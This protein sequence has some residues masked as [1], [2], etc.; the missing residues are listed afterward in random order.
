MKDLQNLMVLQRAIGMV[1]RMTDM[2]WGEDGKDG[3]WIKLAI[4]QVNKWRRISKQPAQKKKP[5]EWP[6]NIGLR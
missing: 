3:C 5:T 4:N 1:D 6:L 2:F